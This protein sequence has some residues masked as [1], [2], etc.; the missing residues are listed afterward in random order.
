MFGSM[1]KYLDFI[2]TKMEF[3]FLEKLINKLLKRIKNLKLFFKK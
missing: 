3:W 1:S 2:D